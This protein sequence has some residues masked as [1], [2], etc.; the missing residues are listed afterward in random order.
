MTGSNSGTS[1][2]IDLRKKQ[3]VG[4]E[5]FARARHPQLGVLMPGAFMPAASEVEPDHAVRTGPG[6]RPESQPRL[7]QL[8][9]NMRLAV[10]IPASALAKVPIAE[11]VE[12]FRPQFE[13]WPGAVIDVPEEQIIPELALADEIA[14]KLRP[15]DVDLAIDNFGRGLFLAGAGQ[16]AAVRRAQDRPRLCRRLRQRQGQCAVVQDRHRPCPRFRQD[17]CRRRHPES[18]RRARPGQHGLRLRSGIPAR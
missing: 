6:A 12:T 9:L 4:V 1:R 13:K 18:V 7:R 8:G 5:A 3:L 17:R 10:N 11:I 2:R 15:L 16:G 14:K